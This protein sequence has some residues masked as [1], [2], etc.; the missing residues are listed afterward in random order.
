V[1][2]IV[3]YLNKRIL[4]VI[5]KSANTSNR[6]KSSSLNSILLEANQNTFVVASNIGTSLW[7][8]KEA[9]NESL[10]FTFGDRDIPI[11]S[12]RVGIIQLGEGYSEKIHQQRR[13]STL[14][15]EARHSDCTGGLN[16]VDLELV[17][18]GGV[19]ENHCGH[20]HVLCPEESDYANLYACD[21]HL[22]GAYGIEYLYHRALDQNCKNC[23]EETRQI[24]RISAN[25]TYLRI[26]NRQDI[27]NQQAPLPNMSS[28]GVNNR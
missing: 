5:P 3:R 11:L 2:A 20:S 18:K 10:T 19:P 22:W 21:G 16:P 6:L 9:Q 23:D 28:D 12:S 26:L 17:S 7:W 24:A 25:D 14:I 8:Q 15:H 27:N 13:I 4:Y 1:S